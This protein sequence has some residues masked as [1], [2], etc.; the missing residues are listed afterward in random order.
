MKVILL[1]NIE[2]IGEKYDVKEVK[3]GYAS[4]FLFP[5][6]LAKPATPGNL[7]WLEAQRAKQAENAQ[8]ELEKVQETVTALDGSEFEILVKVGKGDQ[9]YES[10]TSQKIAELLKKNN[11]SIKKE[12]VQLKEP[13]KELGEF[14]VKINFK[15]NLEGEIKVII[16]PE[17]NS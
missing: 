10:I 8:C 2:N 15:H 1:E 3:D 16:A 13:I 4:N 9:L 11:F 7:R 17:E 14:P 5:K 12:Q 6:S